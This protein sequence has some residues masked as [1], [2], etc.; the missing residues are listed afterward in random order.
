MRLGRIRAGTPPFDDGAAGIKMRAL[1]A[2]G[3]RH[4]EAKARAVTVAT[5]AAP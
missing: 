1:P 4:D 2:G 5:I 3:I